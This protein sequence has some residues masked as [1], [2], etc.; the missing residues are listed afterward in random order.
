VSGP[1]RLRAVSFDLFDT[2][3]DL[4]WGDLA[5]VRVGGVEVGPSTPALHGALGG[6][7][8]VSLEEF[9]EALRHVDRTIRHE[10]YAEGREV[11]TRER[12]ASLLRAL[13]REDEQL[14]E[15]LTAVH[16]ARIRGQVREL[17]H[18]PALLARLHGQL[19]LGVC[20]NFTD[21]RTALSILDAAALRPH[22]DAV[23]ISETV[24]W[25]KPRREIFEAVLG[26]LGVAP[27]ELLHVGD[28]L[29][30]DVA[31]A[32]ALGIRTAWLTRRV[33]DPAAARARYA[34]PPPDVELADLA[35]LP[36]LLVGAS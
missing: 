8:G 35:E 2:L 25:R 34:G 12:F 6:A 24:G 14:V 11:S 13:G 1:P 20:S 33:P 23:A 18:H 32:A 15:E 36:G 3:V 21:A 10:R 5:P 30:A 9:A 28:N 17:G 4:A 29:E 7:C 19:A 16:M 22:L 27:A 31:G 26:A